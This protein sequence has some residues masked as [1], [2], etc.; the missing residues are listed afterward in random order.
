MAW[1]TAQVSR[2]EFERAILRHYFPTFEWHNPAD[3]EHASVEGAVR[4]NSGTT[5]RLRV[6]LSPQFPVICPDLVVSEPSPLRKHNG[7]AL[8]TASGPMHT[9]D[10]R[11]GCTRICHFR[12]VFWAPQ[13]TIY[14]VLLK[15]RIWLEA[16]EAH[17]RTGRPLDA[18][19][20]HA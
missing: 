2:L 5:Y 10:Q 7:K 12:P 19:L 14:L 6:Y 11:D 4:A 9:L 16:Y 17:L 13:N 18:F 20:P 1:S 15:G 8:I 3:A